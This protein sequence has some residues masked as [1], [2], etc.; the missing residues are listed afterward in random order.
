MIITNVGC[1]GTGKSTFSVSLAQ[2]IAQA[3]PRSTILL[4]N[5]SV[6]VPM[7]AVWETNRDV[8]RT[9]SL[10]YLFENQEISQKTLTK[11]IV[12]LESNRNIGTLSFCLGDSPLSYKDIEYKQ[13]IQMLKAAEQLVD[14]VIVDCGSNML[15]EETA[16]SIEMANCLNVFLTPDP[17]G[18][19]YYKTFKLMYGSNAKFLVDN[20]NYLLAPC[21]TF[22]ATKELK[23]ALGINAYEIPYNTEIA[24]KNCEGNIFGV[25]KAS[26]RKYKSIIKKILS[27]TNIKTKASKK[28]KAVEDIDK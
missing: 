2:A 11:S 7:H 25:Y 8:P 17:N 19:V 26:P 10:G 4:I 6:D 13:V 18:V 12:T 21:R 5:Y 16:A 20:T 1:S 9:Y 27:S 15:K 23:S 24:V 14:Y 28:D 3:N 22:H